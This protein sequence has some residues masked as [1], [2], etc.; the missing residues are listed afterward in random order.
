VILQQYVNEKSACRLRFFATLHSQNDDSFCSQFRQV[1]IEKQDVHFAKYHNS[2]SQLMK[3]SFTISR[4]FPASP[5]EIYD[6]WLDSD[7]HTSMT[8]GKANC[9]K[10]LGEGFTAWDGYITGITLDLVVNA[11]ITQTWRTTEFDEEDEDSLLVVH[12]TPTANGTEVTIDHCNIPEGQ[13]QY[14]QGWAENYFAPME[15]FFAKK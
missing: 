2:D 4:S 11:E 7:M 9:S 10:E 5:K 12:L 3:E 15:E 8:G 1:L 14:K 6:A 13:T